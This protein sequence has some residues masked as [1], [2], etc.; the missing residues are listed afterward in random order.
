MSDYKELERKKNCYIKEGRFREIQA[1]DS[2]GALLFRRHF[3]LLPHS[4]NRRF[5]PIEVDGDRAARPGVKAAKVIDFCG[6]TVYKVI[7]FLGG[8]TSLSK[9][10]AW[11]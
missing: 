3:F 7:V 6:G 11:I 1:R 5:R 8:E 10:E 2:V 4:S 9:R